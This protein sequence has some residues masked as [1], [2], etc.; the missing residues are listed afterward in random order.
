MSN[1]TQHV[2]QPENLDFILPNLQHIQQTTCPNLFYIIILISSFSG[3][4]F[5]H[6][7]R[8]INC[9]ISKMFVVLILKTMINYNMIGMSWSVLMY[10][11]VFMCQRDSCRC[12]QR[13]CLCATVCFYVVLLK[14]C[15]IISTMLP[16]LLHISV[17]IFIPH[18]IAVLYASVLHVL[19]TQQCSIIIV[20]SCLIYLLTLIIICITILHAFNY[21]NNFSNVNIVFFVYHI[22]TG[23]RDE[24]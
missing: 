5:V 12:G 14:L 3:I 11:H 17:N 8:N 16:C 13:L 18:F 21:Y 22:C 19:I 6:N 1:V 23:S 9:V 10:L 24:K 7:C 20:M 15:L 2:S 4:G